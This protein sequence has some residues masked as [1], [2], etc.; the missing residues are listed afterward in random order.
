MI[1]NVFHKKIWRNG[2]LK[3]HVE[4]PPFPLIKVNTVTKSSRYCVQIKLCRDPTSEKL[5]LHEFKMAL[6]ENG[7]L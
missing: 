7:K 3:I 4:T 1:N 6:F 2:A 5:Y